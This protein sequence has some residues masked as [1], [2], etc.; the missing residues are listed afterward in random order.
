[1]TARRPLWHR[2]AGCRYDDG[3]SAPLRLGYVDGRHGQIHYRTQGAGPAVLLLHWA[4]SNGR[5]YEHIQPALAAH[6]F[7]VLALDL[8]GFGR[9]HKAAE[10]WTCEQMAAELAVACDALA[11]ERGFAVGGHL[12]A[13][14][15]A[16]L[17]ILQPQRWP[18]IVLDGSP[19]LDAAQMAALMSH[20][21]GMSPLFDASGSHKA[22]TWD[23]T[24][25]FLSEW[26]PDYRATPETIAVQYAYMADYLQMGYA[27]IRG[28]I[29]SDAPKGGLSVYK[30][31]ER[32]PLIHTTVL[33]MTA[34]R[35][36][37]RAG[38]ARAVSLLPGCREHEFPGSH[39]IMNP[40][41]AAEYADVVAAFLKRD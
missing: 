33:A 35:E 29:E 41:R 23:M 18:K 40:A 30:A 20:F 32:W 12:S 3:M 31:I 1:M 22:F 6:G 16:E 38:H 21:A 14:V 5:Q 7:R 9:S 34:E 27:A 36:A 17:A 25:T 11:I 2:D 10:G 37:L 8:P 4:P 19:T 39:P 26:D 15:V 24:E 28:Y 13:A